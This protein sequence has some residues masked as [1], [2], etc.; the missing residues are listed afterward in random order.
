[1]ITLYIFFTHV[2]NGTNIGQE[3][4]FKKIYICWIH[5]PRKQSRLQQFITETENQRI[6]DLQRR[7][8]KK[9]LNRKKKR[10]KNRVFFS[11]FFTLRLAGDHVVPGDLQRAHPRPAQPVFGPP[12][13]ARRPRRE[14][15]QGVGTLGDGGGEHKGGGKVAIGGVGGSP[16]LKGENC[17]PDQLTYPLPS[18]PEEISA[19][20]KT[21]KSGKKIKKSSTCRRNLQKNPPPPIL[22]RHLSEASKPAPPQRG[23]KKPAQTLAYLWKMTFKND[24]VNLTANLR[25]GF[26]LEWC[27]VLRSC[28]GYECTVLVAAAFFYGMDRSGIYFR[29]TFVHLDKNLVLRMWYTYTARTTIQ[30]S[31]QHQTPLFS[32]SPN[33]KA[34]IPENSDFSSLA[35]YIV[36]CARQERNREISIF[37]K[38]KNCQNSVYLLSYAMSM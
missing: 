5:K 16:P 2:N 31:P 26:M 11:C 9:K 35:Q 1:M 19:K 23:K 14:E 37:L 7:R 17:P 36:S 33:E 38:K 15:R 28:W 29:T 32:P 22:S 21:K 13:P 6:A 34:W 10:Q 30:R 18:P 12:R 20:L 4:I 3:N 8:K 27:Y 24:A 25:A